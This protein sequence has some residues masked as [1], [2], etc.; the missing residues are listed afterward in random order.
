MSGRFRIEKRY[1][2]QASVKGRMKTLE[3][4]PNRKPSA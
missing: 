1:G 2:N 3:H 4:E